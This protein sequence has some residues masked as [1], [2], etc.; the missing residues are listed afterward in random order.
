VGGVS[1]KTKKNEINEE[2]EKSD[3]PLS[4]YRLLV[5]TLIHKLW[6]MKLICD[7]IGAS[8]E[9]CGIEKVCCFQSLKSGEPGRKKLKSFCQ[10]AGNDGKEIC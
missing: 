6:K 7:E 1:E 10:H 8:L 5:D 2:T 4:L 9:N 3:F